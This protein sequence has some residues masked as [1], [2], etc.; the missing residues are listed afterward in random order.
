MTNTVN[1]DGSPRSR[2]TRSYVNLE[3]ERVAL[4]NDQVFYHMEGS[5]LVIEGE[6]P[7]GS[8]GVAHHRSNA[9]DRG[10]EWRVTLD[11]GTKL[12][13]VSGSVLRRI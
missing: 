9:G 6:A 11:D 7:A 3:G 4:V 10:L 1:A 12:Y 13:G 5:K 8:T 2:V